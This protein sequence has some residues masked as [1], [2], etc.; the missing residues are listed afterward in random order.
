VGDRKG[1]ELRRFCFD[2]TQYDGNHHPEFGPWRL[3]DMPF[4]EREAL[5]KKKAQEYRDKM[6]PFLQ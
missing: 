4:A 6:L 3:D 1:G 5:N 2:G